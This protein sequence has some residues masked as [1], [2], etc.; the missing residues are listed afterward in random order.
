[1]AGFEVI[2]EVGVLVSTIILM[3]GFQLDAAQATYSGVGILITRFKLE[4]LAAAHDCA[5]CILL[6]CRT[7]KLHSNS[8]KE[9][10][11]NTQLKSSVA[12]PESAMTLLRL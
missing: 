3:G 6:R 9:L 2:T 10:T 4:Q 12:A 8:S 11:R 5:S 1:M 7:I